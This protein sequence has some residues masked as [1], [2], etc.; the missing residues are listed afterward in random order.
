MEYVLGSAVTLALVLLIM[1]G[2][3]GLTACRLRL[4]R[5]QAYVLS[6][7]LPSLVTAPD[8]LALA[9]VALPAV[10]LYE[11]AAALMG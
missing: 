3:V 1:W 2:T 4:M 10:A 6:V 9:A 7:A 11:A 5:K 8:L